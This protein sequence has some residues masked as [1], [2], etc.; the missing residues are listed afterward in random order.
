MSVYGRRHPI[1]LAMEEQ[2]SREKELSKLRSKEK[3]KRIEDEAKNRSKKAE[4]LLSQIKM[5]EL[6][7]A[8]DTKVPIVE[9]GELTV[10]KRPLDQ[11]MPRG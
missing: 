3:S 4:A 6:H 11:T 8:N 7:R 10:L 5:P 9:P 2:V 1:E